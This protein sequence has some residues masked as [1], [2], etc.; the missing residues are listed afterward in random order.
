M[1]YDKVKELLLSFGSRYIISWI[2]KLLV[3]YCSYDAVTAQSTGTQIGAGVIAGI[4]VI[5]D[6]IHARAA[7]AQ[8]ETKAVEASK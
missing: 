4:G 3:A 2:I 8:T 6:V 1:G 5:A 7:K